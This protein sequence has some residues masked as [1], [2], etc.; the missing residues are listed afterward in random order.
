M[1]VKNH[2]GMMSVEVVHLSYYGVVLVYCSASVLFIRVA[3]KP[4]YGTQLFQLHAVAG[5]L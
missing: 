3:I 1:E 2:V 5:F 4:I